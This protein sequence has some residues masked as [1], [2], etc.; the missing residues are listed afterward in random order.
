MFLSNREV[1]LLAVYLF[2]QAESLFL[3]LA[4]RL[5][6]IL[7]PAFVDILFRKPC[8]RALFNLLG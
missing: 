1:N 5:L 3:P 6:I 4:R 2:F 8:L 7:F